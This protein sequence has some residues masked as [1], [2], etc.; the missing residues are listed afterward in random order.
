M[1]F[2]IQLALGSRAVHFQSSRFHPLQAAAAVES[3]RFGLATARI[4]KD[5]VAFVP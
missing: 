1:T 5:L 2:R 4:L 3:E